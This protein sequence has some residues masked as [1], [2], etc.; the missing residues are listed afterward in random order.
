MKRKGT[1]PK[2]ETGMKS[3]GFRALLATQ[4]L[5][6][7]ND[8]AFKLVISLIAVNQFA[9]AQ[10]GTIFL[11][12]SGVL[13]VLPFL[14]FSTYAGFLADRFSKKTIIVCKAG[15]RFNGDNSY[16]YSIS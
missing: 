13:L 14:L 8:N 11:S 9:N 16:C 4:F 12:L 10:G 5:G 2:K 15:N 1:R 6:A 7:F 3:M